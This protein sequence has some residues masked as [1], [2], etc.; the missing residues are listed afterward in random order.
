MKARHSDETK[1]QALAALRCG[2]VFS[3]VARRFSIPKATLSGWAKTAGIDIEQL[4]TEKK[5]A[6]ADLIA[7]YMTTGFKALIAQNIAASDPDY[8][9]RYS[10]ES[11]AILHGVMADKQLRV[12][13]AHVAAQPI[14]A[15]E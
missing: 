8:I 3:D 6:L 5:Q 12:L 2:T 13:E 4:R 1:A 11:L 10:P 7:E 14:E 15:T 9:K